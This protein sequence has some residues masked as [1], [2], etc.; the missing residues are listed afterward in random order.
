MSHITNLSLCKLTNRIHLELLNFGNATIVPPWQGYVSSPVFSRLYY[1]CDGSFSISS[2]DGRSYHLEAGQWYLIP[3]QYSF[4]Y[5]CKEE[6][7]HYYFHLKLYDFDGAD[8]LRNCTAPLLLDEVSV[9]TDF[10]RMCLDTSD[11]ALGLILRQN[12]MQILLT[13]LQSNHIAIRSNDYSP[14][15]LKALTYIKQNL[16]MQLSIAEISENIYVSKSTLTKH[17]KAE[18]GMT[19]NEYI[20]STIMAEAERLLMTTGIA[21]GDISHKFSFSDQLYFSRRFK[22]I[23]GISPREYRKNKLL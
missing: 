9:E 19:V 15:I 3:A 12:I 17:F 10:L 8:L 5:Q 23:F 2:T 6:M 13:A 14:C 11:I 20:C 22:E 1:I 18:L 21:I 7:E 4:Q 16:S